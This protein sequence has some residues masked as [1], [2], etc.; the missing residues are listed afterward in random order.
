MLSKSDDL[1]A[2]LKKYG[3]KLGS[4]NILYF[5]N[6]TYLALVSTGIE[7]LMDFLC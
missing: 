1:K 7:P 6:L 3:S 5:E 4:H 2:Q